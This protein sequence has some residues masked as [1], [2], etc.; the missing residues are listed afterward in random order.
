[1]IKELC[2]N[3]ADRYSHSAVGFIWGGRFHGK[4]ACDKANDL[5]LTLS[6]PVAPSPT[7]LDGA[8]QS[9]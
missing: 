1:M 9:P 2:L 8:V 6:T 3:H 4:N 7:D 5:P